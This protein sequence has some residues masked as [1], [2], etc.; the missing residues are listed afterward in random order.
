MTELYG[1]YCG[2]GYRVATDS[3]TIE[4]GEMFFA[5][6]GENFDGNAYAQSALEKGA[7]WA[8]VNSD[9]EL[10]ADDRFIRVDSPFETLRDLAA[11]HRNHVLEGKRL[12]VIG[13]TGTNGKTTTK[14]LITAVLSKKYRVVATQ[15]NLNNDIGVPLSILKITPDT[16]IAVIEMG[17]SHP[18]DIA[19][20]V[21]VS[22]PDYGLI[23]N[24]GRGHLLGFGSFDGVKAAKGELYKWLSSRD[25]SVVFLNNDD[26]DLREMA[27]DWVSC[28]IWPYGL[29][30][31]G[32]S[33]LPSSVGNPFLRLRLRSGRVVN[34]NLVGAY[35]SANV[36]AALATGGYFGVK[37]D[38]AA[39]A[40]ASYV[41]RNNRS[42]LVKT[43]RNTVI[44]D[45]YNANPSSMK[46]A[47][48]NFAALDAENKLA[49]LGDMR[50]LG[51]ESLAEHEK[52]LAQ[53]R[54]YGI[55]ACLVGEEFSGALKSLGLPA[56]NWYA[57]SELLCTSLGSLSLSGRT[58]LVKGSHS[59]GMEKV[60]E[61]L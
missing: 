2:C 51:G 36:L 8:V 40:I 31:Q 9:A 12:P 26:P 20:L 59:I 45:A 55:E 24:V 41:P 57:T 30:Y 16:Q 7:R 56:D 44:V 37:E 35:N 13:L 14:E 23:T 38:D 53:L 19:R 61:Y 15:G 42:Q 4:G 33:V 27:R 43:A 46:A 47:L 21:K 17:A 10:P 60:L 34:T 48:E 54:E 58:V 1:K 11:W 5:L 52:V 49:L 39:E 22:Q 18:D 50:E 29:K 3:R 25:G 28:H 32:V 6:R